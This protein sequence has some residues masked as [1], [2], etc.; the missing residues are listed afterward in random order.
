MPLGDP[1]R[2]ETIAIAGADRVVDRASYGNTGRAK[3]YAYGCETVIIDGA[4]RRRLGTVSVDQ[5]LPD[6]ITGGAGDYVTRPSDGKIVQT[7]LEWLR[8]KQ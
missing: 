3:G 8:E 7:V 1:K 2:Y 6:K 4:T 5:K